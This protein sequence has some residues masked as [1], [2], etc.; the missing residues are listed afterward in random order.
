MRRGLYHRHLLLGHSLIVHFSHPTCIVEYIYIAPGIFM[1]NLCN[2]FFVQFSVFLSVYPR[3]RCKAHALLNQRG[4]LD[5]IT[6]SSFTPCGGLHTNVAF[7]LQATATVD[8]SMLL[9]LT[10]GP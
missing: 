4:C 6:C 5:F 9:C 3:N 1:G 10:N 2:Y 7:R 8:D